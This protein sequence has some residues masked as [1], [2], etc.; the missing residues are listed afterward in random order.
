MNHEKECRKLKSVFH[1]VA[2]E[3]INPINVKVFGD[4]LLFTNKGINEAYNNLL[5]YNFN[6]FLCI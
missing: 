3:N 4:I 6:L 2:A 5:Q 1:I